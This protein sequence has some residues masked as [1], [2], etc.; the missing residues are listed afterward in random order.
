MVNNDTPARARHPRRRI[1]VVDDAVNTADG[2]S[3]VLRS[4]GHRVFTA[5]DGFTALAVFDDF[6]PDAYLLD[7]SMPEISGFNVCRALR[8]LPGGEWLT[9][10]ALSGWAS[11]EDLARALEAGFTGYLMKPATPG[12]V[13][14]AL[15]A[16]APT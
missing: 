11:D 9:I 13:L 15:S 5:Y 8:M 10:I 16:G 7:L 4:F 6:V 2:M 1:V 3:A 12:E 14:S